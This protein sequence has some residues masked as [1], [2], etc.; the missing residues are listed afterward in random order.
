[1]KTLLAHRINET[2]TLNRNSPFPSESKDARDMV[3]NWRY[4]QRLRLVRDLRDRTTD[5]TG[6][7]S[8]VGTQESER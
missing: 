6:D 3:R 5:D 1:M 4:A 8:M 2:L 7:F